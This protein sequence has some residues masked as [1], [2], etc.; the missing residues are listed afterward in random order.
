MHEAGLK[1]V[2]EKVELIALGAC[3]AGFEV[4]G[5]GFQPLEKKS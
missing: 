1:L 3:H 2:A 4:Q 5:R